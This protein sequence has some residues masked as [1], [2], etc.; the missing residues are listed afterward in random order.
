[1][2]KHVDAKPWERQE[3]ESV[4]AF[5]AFSCYLGM[6]EDRSIRAVAEKLHKSSTLIGRWSRTHGWVE[7]VAAHKND[8]QRAA[9]EEA[10]KKSWMMADRHIRTALSLQDKALEALAKTKPEALDPKTILAFIREATRLERDTRA[11]IVRSTLPDAERE[12]G[13]S[14]LADVITEAWKRRTENDSDQ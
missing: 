13:Q 3:G 8:V 11:E 12:R 5:E 10:L 2:P 9:H 14:T 7:R 4:K 6:G 1:M